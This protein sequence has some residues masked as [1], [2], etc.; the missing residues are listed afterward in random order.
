MASKIEKGYIDDVGRGD[1]IGVGYERKVSIRGILILL[2]IICHL[3]KESLR[4]ID[5]GRLDVGTA[6]GGN[7][8]MGIIGGDDAT[9]FELVAD[10]V[11]YQRRLLICVDGINPVYNFSNVGCGLCRESGILNIGYLRIYPDGLL[12]E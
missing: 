6:V 3:R 10:E 8:R 2:G 4:S 12:K 1:L 5:V 9:S 7:V 11:A